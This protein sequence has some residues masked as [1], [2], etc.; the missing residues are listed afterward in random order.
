MLSLAWKDWE[1]K[2]SN[3][4]PEV[5]FQLY[6]FH[7]S[8]H[9]D[10]A[11]R[12]LVMQMQIFLCLYRPYKESISKEMNNYNDLNLHSVTKLSGWFRYCT[13]MVITPS[14]NFPLIALIYHS[15]NIAGKCYFIKKI[16]LN[17]SVDS[18]FS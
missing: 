1:R 12:H 5:A 7:C 17:L 4:P 8:R 18:Y 13:D 9:S 3:F 11:T 14:Y 2:A 16:K 10:E 6:S 15:R